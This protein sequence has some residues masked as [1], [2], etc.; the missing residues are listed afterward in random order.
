MDD[1]DLGR[2]ENGRSRTTDAGSTRDGTIWGIGWDH[3]VNGVRLLY[4]S[5]RDTV[6]GE[7]GVE[8]VLSLLFATEVLLEYHYVVGWRGSST[9]SQR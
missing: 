5:H 3:I 1:M 6:V 9:H 7:V 4:N 2:N 8:L